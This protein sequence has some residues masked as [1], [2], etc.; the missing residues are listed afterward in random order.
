MNGP[1]AGTPLPD[2]LLLPHPARLD[3]GRADFEAI[4][5]AHDG[6]VA[7]GQ[8]GYVDPA[9]GLFVMT[10]AAL[11]ARGE[12]CTNGCRHCPYAERPTTN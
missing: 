10:A 12:C 11:W 9:T 3:A 1:A 6:A 4:M 8:G 7:N 5:A 2:H